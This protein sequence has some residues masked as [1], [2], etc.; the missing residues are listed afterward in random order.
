MTEEQIKQR[1]C[2]MNEDNFNIPL[3]IEE[4]EEFDPIS[5]DDEPDFEKDEDYTDEEDEV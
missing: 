4:L 3:P 5:D 2:N 1:R